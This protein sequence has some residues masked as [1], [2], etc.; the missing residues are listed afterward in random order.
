[1]I[2]MGRQTDRQKDRK[3][4]R[5][6]G[7]PMEMRRL[8]TQTDVLGQGIPMD[9]N[10]QGTHMDAHGHGTHLDVNQVVIGRTN[11]FRDNKWSEKYQRLSMPEIGYFETVK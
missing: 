11:A 4:D 1:M 5:Q 2:Q 9:A 10:R 3:T 6:E 7:I 8:G